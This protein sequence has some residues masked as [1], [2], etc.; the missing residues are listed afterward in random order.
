MTLGNGREFAGHDQ[1]A[2]KLNVDVYFARPYYSWERGL[3]ENTMD[4]KPKPSD[5]INNPDSPRITSRSNI[6][7]LLGAIFV[8]IVMIMSWQAIDKIKE[9]TRLELKSKLESVLNVTHGAIILF[10]QDRTDDALYWLKNSE[11][12]QHIKVQLQLPRTKKIL[13]GSMA[14]DQMRKILR[15]LFEDHQDLGFFVISRDFINIASMRDENIGE[16]NFLVEHDDYLD[17]IFKGKTQCILP[18]CSR[19]MS[20]NLSGELS[21]N[22]PAMFI[23]IPIYEDGEVVAAFI[24]RIDPFLVFTRIAHMART[25]ETG[26]TYAFN[27]DGYLITE[28]RFEDQIR[29]I[30]LIGKQ[31]PGILSLS[32]RNPGGNMLEGFRPTLEREKLPFTRMVKNAISGKTGTDL[33]GYRDYRGVQVIGAWLWDD[34][35]NYG[36]AFEIN[37]AEAYKSFHTT[38]I[39]IITVLGI[40]IALF[41]GLSIGLVRSNRQTF[42]VNRQLYEDINKRK[43]IENVLQ[44]RTDELALSNKELED[45]AYIASHDLKEPLRGIHNYSSFLIEDYADQLDDEGK[46]KLLTLMKLSQRLEELIS[47]LLYYSRV[48]RIRET[49]KETNLNHIIKQV[50][51]TLKINFEEQ[52]VDMRIPRTLPTIYCDKTRIKDIFFNLITNAVKYNDKEEK[53]IEIGFDKD[54]TRNGYIFY[55]RDNGI[56]IRKKH[57]ESVFAIF[58]RLHGRDKYGG[59]TG[60]GLAIAKKIVENHGG[61]IWAESIFGHGTSFYFTLG[62]KDYQN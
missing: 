53:W 37:V 11:L 44:R 12:H 3:N 19:V 16:I 31:E 54:K 43:Q 4:K 45:F 24:L 49:F 33:N 26:D 48:G 9:Q 55:V 36:L 35:Y 41:L 13:K 21:E 34:N 10:F 5:N 20:S 57:L 7:T 29:Q 42:D 23:G 58:K 61:K 38:R 27:K 1:I 30:G 62:G 14:L 47:S 18:I 25:G 40:T 22:E 51:E 46:R 6:G 52:G 28:C 50:I 8:V 39:I 2:S 60:A 32:I 17:N 56:G 59:G 15:P